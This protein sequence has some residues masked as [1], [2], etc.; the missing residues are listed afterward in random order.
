MTARLVA[1]AICGL[2]MTQAAQA[3]EI[4]LL[5]AGATKEIFLELAA[6][7]ESSTGNKVV[8]TWAGSADIKKRI[9][10]G[11]TYDLVIVGA[12]DVDAF[13]KDGKMMPGSRVDIAGSGVGAAV[14]AGAPKPDIATS[15]AVRNA[16]LAAKMVAYSAGASGVYVQRL[17]ERLGIA[18]QMKS[19]SKQTAPGVR[20]AQYLANGEAD[21][22][23]QQ[24]SELVHETGIDFIGPLPADIQNITNYSSGIP[25]GSNAPEPARALQAVLSAPAAAAVI[26]KNGME[27]SRP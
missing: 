14:K 10:A 7:F 21:L 8:A 3:A 25:V 16:M 17:F 1:A 19:R 22:G 9:G 13:I 27:P 26:R 12:D 5:A 2:L 18:G 24:V 20:V 11:E 4:R 23:F 15:E 6:P